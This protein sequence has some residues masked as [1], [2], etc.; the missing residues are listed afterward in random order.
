MHSPCCRSC[1]CLPDLPSE[2][3]ID[4][5]QKLITDC[6]HSVYEGT[7]SFYKEDEETKPVNVY[8]KSKVEAEKHIRAHW[9]N[10]AVLRS[11]IIY[12]PQPVVPV[13]KSL[14]VQVT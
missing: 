11:S 3:A 7:K 5:T 8:G 9:Q 2:W 4:Q 6:V 14:P 13:Q 12:G 10:F 1:L